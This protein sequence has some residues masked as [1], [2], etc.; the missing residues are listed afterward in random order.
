MV[1]CA[2]TS[3]Q[4]SQGPPPSSTATALARL[5]PCIGISSHCS[6]NVAWPSLV[7]LAALKNS[8]SL[9]GRTPNDAIPSLAQHRQV[10][11][12]LRALGS[13]RVGLGVV[14]RPVNCLLRVLVSLGC[15]TSSL[16]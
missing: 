12:R 15:P 6:T 1:L 14:R 5:P 11:A 7:A 10:A 2:P 8:G 9:P 16:A 13:P 4:L 3:T